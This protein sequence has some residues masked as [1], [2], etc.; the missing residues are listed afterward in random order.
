PSSAHQRT[1]GV[2]VL[3]RYHLEQ[4]EVIVGFDA[5]FLGTWISPVEF[6]RG[7]RAGRKLEG[8]SPACTLHVQFESRLSLAGA[9]A[10][11]RHRLTPAEVGLALTH[12]AD[13]LDRRVNPGRPPWNSAPLQ[14]PPIPGQ[15]LDH[16]ASELL[17]ARRSLVLCGSQDVEHQLLCNF[18]N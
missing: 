12:L 8:E 15:A 18:I 3:P 13:R 17:R 4:A 5:D 2:R 14:A 6:T 7:Y 11:Q 9:K 1:H 10:D 16:L